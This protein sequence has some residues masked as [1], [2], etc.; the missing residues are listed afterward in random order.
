MPRK[1]RIEYSGALYHVIAR[2]NQKQRIFE[3]HS[4]FRKYLLLLTIYPKFGSYPQ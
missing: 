1:P 4:D 3:D 2:G